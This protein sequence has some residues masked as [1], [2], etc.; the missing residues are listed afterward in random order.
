MN[1]VK[2]DHF[3]DVGAVVYSLEDRVGAVILQLNE[4]QKLQP[5]V[6]KLVSVVFEELKIVANC[7]QNFIKLW[8]KFAIALHNKIVILISRLAL[9]TFACRARDSFGCG[10]FRYFNN[11]TIFLSVFLKLLLNS[12]YDVFDFVAK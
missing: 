11:Q 7:T 1:V 12:S 2:F 4:V 9:F 3:F 10:S 6:L 8:L 5:E